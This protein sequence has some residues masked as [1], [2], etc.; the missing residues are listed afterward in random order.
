[1]RSVEEQIASPPKEIIIFH[2]R[3]NSN[4]STITF[5]QQTQR[6]PKDVRTHLPL[7]PYIAD[8]LE[9][10]EITCS[11]EEQADDQVTTEGTSTM[12]R[13]N[14]RD[15]PLDVT[16]SYRR[17]ERQRE[18]QRVVNGGFVE[19]RGAAKS[20]TRGSAHTS[21][22]QHKEAHQ[23]LNAIAK[24]DGPTS[25]ADMLANVPVRLTASPSSSCTPLLEDFPSNK[26]PNEEEDEE[27][28]R[29]WD[30]GRHLLLTMRHTLQKKEALFTRTF[31]PI[32]LPRIV[33][34]II[35]HRRFHA[36]DVRCI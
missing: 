36:A 29:K 17:R 4:I 7:L 32:L 21:K 18:R 27:I 15:S 20:R 12:G 13:N 6:P 23:L 8:P 10:T 1:M 34:G 9:G 11:L 28:R 30:N 25:K 33:Q 35:K 19:K 22:T 14:N 24:H 3:R 16:L 26:N 5:A 31:P 2:R